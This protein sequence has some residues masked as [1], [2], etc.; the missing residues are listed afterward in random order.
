MSKS[1]ISFRSK[2]YFY[3][4]KLKKIYD[5]WENIEEIYKDSYMIKDI[6]VI[7][8]VIIHDILAKAKVID[9]ENDIAELPVTYRHSR[10]LKDSGRQFVSKNLGMQM[11]M[12]NIR[13]TICD[14]LYY[15]LDMKSAHMNILNQYCEQN[16]IPHEQMKKACEQNDE[17]IAEIM[18][19]CNLPRDKA[20][21][22]R[23]AVINGGYRSV[24][25]SWW[26]DFTKEVASIHK[27]ILEDAKNERL[28]KLIKNQDRL[29]NSSERENYGG[30]VMN[31]ILCQI[32]DKILMS[33]VEFLKSKKLSTSHIVL[34]FDGFM[35]PC[36]VI[37]PTP[38]F[39]KELSD[40]AFDKTGYRMEFV[41]K[42]MDKIIKLDGYELKNTLED[43]EEDDD[44]NDR[45]M[46]RDDN[47]ATDIL[48]E[49]LEGKIYNC[50][51]TTYIKTSW[52]KIWTNNESKIRRELVL[53]C[54]TLNLYIQRGEYVDP[55][56]G[57]KTG[58][59]HMC[60]LIKDKCP[61]NDKLIDI[62]REKSKGK[63]F[64]QDK[65]YDF[66]KGKF[67]DETDDDM[68]VIRIKRNMP[69][70]TTSKRG[71]VIKLLNSIFERNTE[72]N[73][74][75]CLEAKN[76][77]QYFSRALAGH[78]EDKNWL[79]GLG[80]RDCG[81][82]ILTLLTRASFDGYVTEVDA[83]NFIN[84][85]KSNNNDEALS[86]KWLMKHIW[87]RIL[88]GN[89]V[90]ISNE[91]E[92]AIL[93]G[94]LI[95]SLASGGDTQTI[96]TLYKTEIEFIFG[97]LIVI[98][99]NEMPEV[100]PTDTCQTLS[101]FEFPNK[102]IQ[103]EIYEQM[104][105][106]GSL[107]IY[108]KKGIADLKRQIIK[109]EYMD[110]YVQIV[111]DSYQINKV[112]NCKSVQDASNEYRIDSGD[113]CLFFKETFEFTN[114]KTDCMTSK[115]ITEKVQE[116]FPNMSNQKIKSFL[117]KNMGLEY[118]KN[119]DTKK[120]KYNS[121]VGYIGLKLKVKEEENKDEKE[122]KCLL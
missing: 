92:K 13:H 51:D 29:E 73:D 41:C 31:H 22:V 24:P 28:L 32:E 96:R 63:I 76:M 84:K 16:N 109:T 87:S 49:K 67:R 54:I 38:H 90:D 7:P 71:E 46:V 83:N 10:L 75:L 110:A 98:F 8:K 105:N 5:N 95:K 79:V 55:Y 60:S 37:N 78:L 14:G 18:K 113:D 50:Q 77:I 119:L 56:S 33:C 59:D 85:S 1:K 15:D 101:L 6:K 117:T 20:K 122:K 35:I 120:D 61:V 74:E 88:F 64:F 68:A 72:I 81:K 25:V 89:E 86:K 65:V 107:S 118:T 114:K 2:D 102:F 27:A 17:Q 80:L 99:L 91:R 57:N 47:E 104:C 121:R 23:L 26:L 52:S 103:P 70:D 4:S 40:Y 108:M 111:L 66:S 12:T 42:P 34:E 112:M 44:T 48:L 58:I 39:L 3:H 19:V 69:R 11:M 53:T 82:G 45:V 21:K 36:E 100:R 94:I 30:R 106:D 62:I 115:D 116:K 97:G 93:N 43:T 9:I